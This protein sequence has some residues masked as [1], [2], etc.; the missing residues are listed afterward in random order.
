MHAA[1]P[2]VIQ[3]YL[4]QEC[5]GPDNRT[6]HRS[7]NLRECGVDRGKDREKAWAL[8]RGHEVRG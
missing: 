7:R 6:E 5:R 4:R 3:Q 1:G 8:E 2:D